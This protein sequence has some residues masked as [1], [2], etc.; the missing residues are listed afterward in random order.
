VNG[1]YPSDIFQAIEAQI[2][3]AAET[4]DVLPD[5]GEPSVFHRELRATRDAV[6]DHNTSSAYRDAVWGELM[7]RT[8]AGDQIW[9]EIAIWMMVPKLRAIARRIC[10]GA[11]MELSDVQSEV[12]LGFIEGLRTI[13]PSSEN[14]EW[15][16]RR[17]ASHRGWH[18]REQRRNEIPV[19]DINLVAGRPVNGDQVGDPPVAPV[20]ADIIAGTSEDADSR[21]RL[22]GERLGSV[23]QRLGLRDHVRRSRGIETGRPTDA[24]QTNGCRRNLAA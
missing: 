13:D 3:A 10:R 21:R 4:G 15:L 5:A 20:H 7:R 12:I 6:L 19:E 24:M 23:A 9:Q 1:N 17:A 18:V 16:L 11:P 8:R 2:A 14:L 22:E